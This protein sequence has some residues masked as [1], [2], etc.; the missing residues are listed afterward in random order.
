MQSS[1]L[2]IE[3]IWIRIPVMVSSCCECEL[4][5]LP[6]PQNTTSP[7]HEAEHYD[8]ASSLATTTNKH[9]SKPA[10]ST[11]PWGCHTTTNAVTKTDGLILV[12][13]ATKPNLKFMAINAK[14][15]TLHRR[16]LWTWKP[17]ECQ[18]QNALTKS[19]FYKNQKVNIMS[20][21]KQTGFT[22]MSLM[23]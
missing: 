4:L 17:Q 23:C 14:S 11:Q 13:L 6:L 12:I 21:N 8:P 16:C 19:G 10:A 18:S 2:A 7:Y 9:L 20:T 3:K 5:I 15:L 22:K 1:G